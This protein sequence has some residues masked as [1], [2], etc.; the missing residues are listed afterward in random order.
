MS[1]LGL[2]PLSTTLLGDKKLVRREY[3]GENLLKGVSWT[4][5]EIHL[6]RSVCRVNPKESLVEK[7]P[8]LGGI[9]RDK[10]LI[11]TYIHGWF[12]NHKVSEK[13]FSLILGKKFNI[14]VSFNEIKNQEMNELAVF[15]EKHCDVD[16]ILQ[17]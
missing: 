5:Y 8:T 15:L 13:I 17:F 16:K 3:K 4:G 11:G 7:D 12:E 14:P 6:G 1:A 2:L 10:K 9:D